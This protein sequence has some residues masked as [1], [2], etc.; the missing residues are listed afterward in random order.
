MEDFYRNHSGDAFGSVG[1]LLQDHFYL[2]HKRKKSWRSDALSLG[3][4]DGFLSKLEHRKCEYTYLNRRVVAYDNLL[5]DALHDIPPTLLGALLQEELQHSGQRLLFSETAT[6]G[7]L[8]HATLPRDPWLLYAA[9]PASSL[10]NFQRVSLRSEEGDCP[11]LDA[12]RK[13]ACVDL[14]G[15]VRQISVSALL[16]DCCV[17]V[18]SDYL[19]GVWRFNEVD[20]PKVLQVITTK[21]PV[22]CITASPHVLG[23]VLLADES[24]SVHL[25]TVGKGMTQ[26]RREDSNLYFNAS[27]PWRW[28]EF[29]AH[30]RVMLYGDRTGMEL[31]DVR[32]ANAPSF[33]LF[34]ISRSPQCRS[35]ERVVLG[36]Y[37][38]DANPFHHLVTTQYSAYIMDER[39]PVLPMLKWDHMM[40]AP[41]IF[42]QV[43]PGHASSSVGG[44][45]S[46]KVV[47]GSQSSQEIVMLQYSGGSAEPCVS[48]GSPQQLLSPRDSL[49]HLP[50]QLP[51]RTEESRHRLALP[52]AGMTCFSGRRGG[53][54]G[55]GGEDSICVLQLTE[56]GD[57]FYQVLRPELGAGPDAAGQDPPLPPPGGEAGGR[58][59]SPSQR[60]AGEPRPG[61][62][63]EDTGSEEEMIGPTQP[64]GGP[65]PVV[66]ET[67]ERGRGSGSSSEEEG[68]GGRRGRYLGLE[69]VVNEEEGQAD[70]A[71]LGEK[72]EVASSVRTDRPAPPSA[73]AAEAW[74]RWLQQ[75]LRCRSA[76]RAQPTARKR[77][78]AKKGAAHDPLTED[79]LQS[80]RR[81]LG[82]SMLGGS[83][84]L[85]GATSLPAVA[86]PRLPDTVRTKAWGDVLSQR[87]TVSWQ[88]EEQW[89]AWWSDKLGLNRKERAEALKRRR[90][91]DKARRRSNRSLSGSSLANPGSSWA[92]S[93][94]D[95]AS[96]RWSEPGSPRSTVSQSARWSEPGSP[97][98]TVSQS[99]RWSEPGSPRSTVSQSARWSEPGS[100]RS[101]VSQSAR[102]SEPDS[103]RSTVSRASQLQH[104]SPGFSLSGSLPNPKEGPP[105]HPRLLDVEDDLVPPSS[106]SQLVAGGSVPSTPRPHT[107]GPLTPTPRTPRR[108]QASQAFLGRPGSQTSAVKRKRSQMGF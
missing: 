93:D 4:T 57:V 84:L 14:K 70:A 103:P 33:T 90:S 106:S 9:G 96:S 45:S 100:P 44:S 68:L 32:A 52:A 15:P 39:F 81:D 87:L 101:T 13:P 55:G 34:R 54:G 99:A 12:C 22:T 95:D 53:G 69:V 108:S 42:A 50:V 77:R 82:E 91:R 63:A 29:S 67:P 21:Q 83:L 37:L 18:R 61:L 97:R 25:W 31:T 107:P 62:V 10:L 7:A 80:L 105:R 66:P 40:Q 46:T 85:H 17:A 27:S 16:S 92:W 98:S 23:E 20:K 65:P 64:P 28:C 86:P 71:A 58:G 47:I 2:G 104:W 51:H 76:D 35:G 75:L 94:P 72:G 59:G 74:R 78:R 56:A 60:S 30:P 8:A 6:G 43:L 79:R 102:W 11:R 48:L 26:V 24:G 89:K 38:A 41:P 5:R 49:D 36:R 1:A 88:G 19:C 73:R 3:W